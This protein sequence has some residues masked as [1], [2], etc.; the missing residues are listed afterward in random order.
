LHDAKIDTLFE[1]PRGEAV[2]EGVA[3]E[4]IAQQALRPRDADR[5]ADRVLRNVTRRIARA[6]EKPLTAAMRRPD[7]P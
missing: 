7:L 6:R 2:P 3:G 1:Q 4:R 5:L